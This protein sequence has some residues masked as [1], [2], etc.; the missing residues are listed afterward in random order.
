MKMNKEWI[1]G[2]TIAQHDASICLLHGDEIVLYIAEERIS[3][4]K[5]DGNTPL[6]SLDLIKNYTNCIDQLVLCNVSPDQRK[7][8]R[9]HLR[10]IAWMAK[11]EFCVMKQLA[12][13]SQ[14]ILVI[15]R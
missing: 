13:L 6:V 3:K 11:V 1:L 9:H 12:F 15:F 7:S 10:K 4:I 14:I 2:V 8:I 5:H